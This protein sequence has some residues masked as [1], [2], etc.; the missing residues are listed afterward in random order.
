MLFQSTFRLAAAE[1]PY[2][3][4]GSANWNFLD[5][6]S[7]LWHS[8]MQ[9]LSE[10]PA[11]PIFS[12]TW[13]ES[14]LEME[15]SDFLETLSSYMTELYCFCAYNSTAMKTSTLP[16]KVQ[17]PENFPSL[18]SGRMNEE[19][20]VLAQSHCINCLS[21]WR[22]RFS[23]ILRLLYQRASSNPHGCHSED[24]SI[25][26]YGTG[27][28]QDATTITPNHREIVLLAEKQKSDI[29]ISKMFSHQH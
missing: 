22:R 25:A 16:T 29:T 23:S 5:W 18:P 21:R 26:D 4:I 17:S 3:I 1:Y 28:T 6:S 7:G 14:T 12:T 19:R 9:E 2:A 11:A 15:A 8:F 27:P 24:G 10:E 20:G 13:E